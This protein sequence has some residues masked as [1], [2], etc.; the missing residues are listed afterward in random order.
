MLQNLALTGRLCGALLYHPPGVPEFETVKPLFMS[1][2]WVK[3][4]PYGSDAI[5]A[6]LSEGF[7]QPSH[8]PLSEAYQRLFIGP[9]AL[10]APPWGSVYLDRE[11]VVFGDSTLALRHWLSA[12][13]ITSYHPPQEPEDHIGLLLLMAA[14]LA[15]ERPADVDEFLSEHL[16][17]WAPHYLTLLE[18]AARHP[19]YQAA[20]SLTHVTLSGWRMVREIEVPIKIL[21]R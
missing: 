6:S 5:L 1:A 14:W 7:S 11:S 3:A 10:A 12:R 9:D 17:P 13:G 16:L 21:Y 18:A 15:E 19:F 8:E 2:A 20:A 4:W